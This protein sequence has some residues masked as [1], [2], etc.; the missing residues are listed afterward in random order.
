MTLGA[1]YSGKNGKV[2]IGSSDILDCKNWKFSEKSNNSQFG[3]SSSAGH[4]KSVAGTKSGSVTFQV[5]IAAGD[6]LWDRFRPGDAVTLLL[7]YDATHSFSVPVRIDDMEISVDVNE[8][9]EVTVDVTA[10]TN[11][12]WTYPDSQVSV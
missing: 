3:S 9:S 7:Y 5:A 10:S 4:K 2:R 12:A 11:G 8:G 1:N 6:L